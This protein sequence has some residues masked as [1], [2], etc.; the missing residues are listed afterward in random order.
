MGSSF[1]ARKE[2]VGPWSDGAVNAAAAAEGENDFTLPT[3]GRRELCYAAAARDR[4]N[5]PVDTWRD[6]VAPCLYDHAAIPLAKGSKMLSLA[7]TPARGIERIEAEAIALI[8]NFR[9]EA[10][11]E[12]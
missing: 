9:D 10:Y 8:S 1:F 2:P 5:P 12:A 7:A 6:E 4:G 11:S 3:L